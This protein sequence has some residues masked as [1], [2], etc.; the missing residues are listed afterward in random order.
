MA[1]MIYDLANIIPLSL[2]AAFL[3]FSSDGRPAI[4]IAIPAVLIP[5]F[6]VIFLH[7]KKR[8]R[9]AFSGAA[10]SLAAGV[11][12]V[13]G[14]EAVPGLVEKYGWM[15]YLLMVCIGIF[16]LEEAS[17]RI[18]W[19]K[20]IISAFLAAVLMY[21]LFSG[22]HTGRI[23][24]AMI[25]FYLLLAAAQGTELFWKKEGEAG[26]EKR[27]TYILPFPMLVLIILLFLKA[28]EKPYD[29]GPVKKA[30]NTARAVC[31]RLL[32]SVNAYRGWDDQEAVMGFSDSGLISGSIGESSFPALTVK[33]DSIYDGRIYLSGRSFDTFDGREWTKTDSSEKDA[34]TYD[35]LLTMAGL[36]RYGRGHLTD[37]IRSRDIT[38]VYEGIR[39]SCVFTPLKTLP[40]T[41]DRALLQKGGD[42]SFA[43]RKL[44]SYRV[45]GYWVNRASEKYDEF[46]SGQ[47]AIDEE[48]FLEAERTVF[49]KDM[50][51]YSYEGLLDSEEHIRQI[52][53]K[54]PAV[55]EK[56]KEYLEDLLA[57][58][59]SDAEKLAVI[60][61]TL[62]A[63]KYD[64]NPGEIPS[65]VRDS[66]GF[67][68]HLMFEKKSG[69][70]VHYATAFV[71]LS[72]AAGI[73][74]RY[75]Q[76]YSVRMKESR[77]VE[78]KS[79]DAHAWPEVYIRG[80]GWTV[81]EPT[82]GFRDA[83]GWD[84]SGAGAD[85]AASYGSYYATRYAK[86]LSADEAEADVKAG[87]EERP[88][89]LRIFAVPFAS[90]LAFLILFFVIDR[91]ARRY[92]YSRMDERQKIQA[93]AGRS[94][95]L[96]RKNGYRLL[97]GQTID[98]L[99]THAE[100][101]I[102]GEL[103]R[104]LEIYERA[105]YAKDPPGREDVALAER[106]C[107]ELALYLRR[108]KYMYNKKEGAYEKKD[109]INK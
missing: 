23:R 39:T 90:V 59:E 37:L 104:P 38:V 95:K 107:T 3:L 7:M 97:P 46:L 15:L 64:T 48:D 91:L 1:G 87:A 53:G 108:K 77:S 49:N 96:L 16:A 29:W 47:Q 68:D 11:L 54:A 79:S 52:Y 89:D 36:Q 26:F 93:L 2:A 14:K 66:A 50:P 44:R 32:L 67:L 9:L 102:P 5:A 94:L 60:E 62:S 33:T 61:R 51:Q 85:R 30:V 10:L 27:I 45:H 75:V 24:T 83:F 55:S 105:L 21:M 109:L 73:P 58:C 31:E 80:A 43:G 4:G 57:G 69:Y 100:T 56:M 72:R 106:G 71:L 82:P 99:K 98:E 78:A 41:S 28:P 88:V 40:L 19:L 8:G 76:G 34:V 13:T 81:Y 17:H 63:M 35:L 12:L 20:L 92:R 6:C 86:T 103:L 70:C 42:L 84:T 74:A 18:R 101:S 25:L 22:M 65:T